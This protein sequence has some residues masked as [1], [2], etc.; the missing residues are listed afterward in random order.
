[1]LDVERRI[2]VDASVE[3]FLHV[4]PALGVAASGRIGVC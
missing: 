3:Q 4:L 2:N 1:M